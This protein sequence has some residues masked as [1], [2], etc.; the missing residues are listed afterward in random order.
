MNKSISRRQFLSHGAGFALASVLSL[1]GIGA[2]A[3][4]ARIIRHVYT[5]ARKVSLTYDDLWSEYYTLRIG[6]EYYRRNIRL[7]LFPAGRAVLNNLERPNPGYENLYP[8]L[9]DMGHEFGCHLFTHRVIRDFSL[10]QLTEEEME[11]A[12]HT[13]RRALGPGFHPVGI[14]PPY[15][16][17]TEAVKELSASYGIPLI[18]WGLDSQDAVCTK[19]VRRRALRMRRPVDVRNFRECMGSRIAGRNLQRRAM[20]QAMRRC[21]LKELRDLF[22]SGHNHFASYDKNCF[23]GDSTDRALPPFLEYAAR[24]S[25]SATHARV[26]TP[27]T[28]GYGAT[29]CVTV[30]CVEEFA[31]TLQRLWLR[32]KQTAD[33]RPEWRPA[34]MAIQHSIILRSVLS[35]KQQCET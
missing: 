5:N 13:M 29:A 14:R 21:N 9:R 31:P 20:R 23:S 8:R 35:F 30:N 32:F 19:R 1:S 17:V 24:S 26:L 18:L 3:N 15:G 10:Q 2:S 16:H 27:S 25:L 28:P 22:A 6:R 4:S 34:L 11:P 33:A 7:T 12:L